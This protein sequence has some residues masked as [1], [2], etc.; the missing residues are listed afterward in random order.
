MEG[1][2]EVCKKR[3]KEIGEEAIEKERKY[4][5]EEVRKNRR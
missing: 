1:K 4:V 2:K 5:R 3:R